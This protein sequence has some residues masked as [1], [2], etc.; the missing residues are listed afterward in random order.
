MH[1]ASDFEDM[2]DQSVSTDEDGA[3]SA[4]ESQRDLM[5]DVKEFA[6]KETIKVRQW[7]R[8]ALFMI[9]AAGVGV[10]YMTYAFL[11]SEENDNHKEAVR[12]QCLVGDVVASRFLTTFPAKL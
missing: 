7:R 3:S 2:S 9:F 6:S 5:N 10:S 8:T 4:G 12:V 1:P 11:S